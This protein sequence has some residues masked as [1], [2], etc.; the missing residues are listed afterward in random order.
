VKPNFAEIF[1]DK[2]VK[3]FMGDVKMKQ[4]DPPL[5]EGEI[6][7]QFMVEKKFMV[8]EEYF[9]HEK[10][11][12]PPI[13]RKLAGETEFT[14][15]ERVKRYLLACDDSRFSDIGHIINAEN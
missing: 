10:Y 6:P 1:A 2:I 8:V 3:E 14:H 12:L 15:Q 7:E 4:V 11:C 13:C 5:K 9:T